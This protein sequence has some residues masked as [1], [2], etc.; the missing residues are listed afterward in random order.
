MKG[1]AFHCHHDKLVEFA[2][3]YDERVTFIKE[4]KP[5]EEIALRLRLFQMIP[6]ERLSKRGL[7]TY[8]KAWQAYDKAWQACDKARQA[9]LE[10]N[11]KQ[12]EKLHK[13]LCPN[14]PWDGETIFT[15][16][17]DKGNWY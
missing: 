17:D 15:R 7:A 13:E 6:D 2:Y 5:E 16:K 14:C 3:D 8:V 10:K 4:S 12:L 9:Y 11:I 1:L